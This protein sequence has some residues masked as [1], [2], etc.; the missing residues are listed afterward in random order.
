MFK[1]RPSQQTGITFNNQI[2]ETDS[3]NI[4]NNEYIFNGGGV[5]IG[6]FNNDKKPDLYFTGNQ[7]ANRLYLNQ[8]NLKFNDVTTVSGTAAADRWSTGVAVVDI[9]ADGW[10]DIYVCAAMSPDASKRANLLFVNQGLDGNGIP[11]FEEMGQKYGIDASQNS[12]G[13]T[14]FDYDKDGFLDLYVLNNEQVHTL[15]TNYRP[16]IIDGSAIS[17]DRLYHNNGNGTFTDVTLEAGITI[18]GFGLGI[19][20]ADLNYDGWPDLYVCNDYLTNDLLYINNQDGTF[21]NTIKEVVRHQSKFSMGSDISDY[22]NDGYLDI[23]TLDMLG[24]TNQRMKTTNGHS[25][26]INYIFNERW[27]YEYQYSRNM[28]QMGNGPGLPFSEIGLMAGM[29]RTDWSWSPLFADMDNDGYRDLLITN[30]FP[31]DIT[32]MDFG[33]FR[34]G[35]SPFMSPAKILD[36]IPIVKIPNYAFKNTGK[37]R[38]I[39]I[40]ENWGLN[41]P[42][43]SNGAA[44]ADLDGDGDLDYV[45]NNI[46][47]EAFLFENTLEQDKAAAKAY[48]NVRFEGTKSNPLG[49][50]AKLVLRFGDGQFQYYE[51]YL[52]RGY[53]SSVDPTAHFGLGNIEKISAL[54]ILWPNG[55][56]RSIA[57]VKANQTITLSHA[58]AKIASTEVLAFPLGPLEAKPIFEEVS[59]AIGID[60]LHQERDVIDYNVQRI[61]PHKLTQ[62]GPCLAVGDINGDRL[63]DFMVGSAAGFSPTLFL[64]NPDGTF[65]GRE[66]FEAEGDK[67]FEEEGMA[68]FDLENDG[69]LDLYLVSGSNEFTQDSGLYMDR[70]YLNDGK[71]NFLRATDKMPLVEASGSVVRATDFDQDG[72]VDLFV[73]GRTPIGQFPLSDKSYLLKNNKGVLEDVTETWAPD[74]R[75]VGMVT[76]AIWADIDQDDLEDLV[77]VGELMPITIFRNNKTSLSIKEK[78]GLDSLRGWWES[79]I[80]MDFDLDG[81][82]DLVAGNLGENNFFQA[83]SEKPVTILAK[84]FDKNG[85]VDPIM[86]AHLKKDRLE[87]ESYPVNFWG[88]LFGQSPLFRTK[89]DFYRDY[90]KATQ[91]DLLSSEELKGTLKLVGNYDKTSYFENLGNGRFKPVVLPFPAQIAPINGMVPFDQN[92][93]GHPDLLLIGND[94]GNETFIGRYDAFNGLLLLGDGKGGFTDI[95]AAQSGFLVDGDAKSIVTIKS[96]LG[97]PLYVV[98]QN[99]GRLLVFRQIE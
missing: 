12:M 1:L 76:D 72:F 37:G 39:D 77:V 30:G 49:I 61:L 82:L 99:K 70:L 66:L 36:S 90:A 97:M 31:R 28:L 63:E 8:G 55:R 29:A 83:S 23:I 25:N 60:Y 20:V 35:M 5:A 69:D 40:G 86:F 13:A 21:S 84:D 17:N 22:N 9:N 15:P 45:V 27:G 98:G 26:Y 85:S 48:L 10:L 93:D 32:D 71:G 68:L 59:T 18:E 47:E 16:K 11:I 81:D 64:Q 46:N 92:K 2:V 34:I 7:V 73:G 50:G 94:Y 6:D 58:N 41:R 79:V 57:D 74:L 51:H 14:F 4:L 95:P 56:V 38:F 67:A 88:D 44:F 65:Y 42:S 91:N 33:N 87:Y 43:F 96:A 78:S 80:A 75:K 19:A 24:E 53:M 52:S 3:F 62:N 54:E 89:F